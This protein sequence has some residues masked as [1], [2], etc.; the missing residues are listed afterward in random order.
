MTNGEKEINMAKVFI[1]TEIKLNVNIAEI[2]G[3][4]MSDY[5]FDV[6]IVGGAGSKK[7]VVTFSKKGAELSDGLEQG[8]DNANYIVV[9][10]TRELGVGKVVCRVVAYIPDGSFK[11]RKRTEIAEVNT[12]IEVVIGSI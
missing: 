4:N 1:G 5:D 9:F 6:L 2:D 12:G 7:K 3:K 8:D 10:D 11:D